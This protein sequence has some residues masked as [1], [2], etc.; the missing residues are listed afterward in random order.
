MIQ[1]IDVITIF[2]INFTELGKNTHNYENYF[3]F[4][5]QTWVTH[6]IVPV[7]TR[8]RVLKKTTKTAIFGCTQFYTTLLNPTLSGPPQQKLSCNIHLKSIDS[9]VES[10][11]VLFFIKIF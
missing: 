2:L 4:A 5:E 10:F 7:R 6:K 1:F 11:K 3:C 9:K 8:V